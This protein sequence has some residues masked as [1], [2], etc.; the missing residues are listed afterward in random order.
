MTAFEEIFASNRAEERNGKTPEQSSYCQLDSSTLSEQFHILNTPPAIPPLPH[1]YIQVICTQDGL[2]L[3]P[4]QASVYK[5][6]AAL[7]H[8][9]K[10]GGVQVW[11]DFDAGTVGKNDPTCRVHGVVGILSLFEGMSI[12]R[13]RHV[14]L[15]LAHRNLSTPYRV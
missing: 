10:T 1:K 6:R 3:H 4:V 14:L 8:W 5:G 12:T 13:L 2:V 7:I 9:N 11:N 15:S